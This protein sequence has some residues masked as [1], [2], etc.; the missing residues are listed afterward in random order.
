MLLSQEQ[1]LIMGKIKSIILKQKNKNF[2]IML[3]VTGMHN[4]KKYGST[5]DQIKKD[6]IKNVT[7]FNQKDYDQP[8]VI[9]A[10]TIFGFKKFIKNKLNL[11]V[12]HGDRIESLACSIAGS[13]NNI[14]VYA[15]EGG[16]I[17]RTLDEIFRHS[18]SKISNIHFVTNKIAKKG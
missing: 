1:E 14:K 3:F 18:I 16:E 12:V 4:I 13:I 15:I 5:Y 6:K 7:R 11:I 17:S 9:L 10:N 8:D 2:K